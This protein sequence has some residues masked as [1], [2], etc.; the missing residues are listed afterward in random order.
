MQDHPQIIEA[1]NEVLA[2]EEESVDWHE[3]HST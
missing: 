2:D 1:L 3:G